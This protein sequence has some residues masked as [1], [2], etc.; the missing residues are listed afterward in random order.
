VIK[1]GLV[2]YLDLSFDRLLSRSMQDS[3]RPG[4]REEKSLLLP[5]LYIDSVEGM[6][7]EELGER[8]TSLLILLETNSSTKLV[9][10]ISLIPVLFWSL[11]IPKSIAVANG[12]RNF[13]FILST[14]AVSKKIYF[15]FAKFYWSSVN[16]IKTS[17]SFYVS[18]PLNHVPL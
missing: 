5:P 3:R 9:P 7:P 15:S 4:K 12:S 14:L 16:L 10:K 11:I 17:K 13:L 2:S 8:E 1:I 18:Y 6:Y